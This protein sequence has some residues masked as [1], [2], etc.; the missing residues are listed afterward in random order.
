MSDYVTLLGTE[1]VES[2]ARTMSA[3]ADRMAQAASSI[4]ESNVRLQQILEE[5][6]LRFERAI[7]TLVECLERKP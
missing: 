1:R 7:E 3:A 2:A 6:T 4:Y 5:H